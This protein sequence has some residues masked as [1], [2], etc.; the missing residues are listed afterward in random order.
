MAMQAPKELLELAIHRMSTRFSPTQRHSGEA[1]PGLYALLRG[2]FVRQ[3]SAG[4]YSLLPNGERVRA[5]IEGIIDQEMHRIG[6]LASWSGSKKLKS[7][8]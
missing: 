4:V 2:G 5:K 1:Q 6:W 8:A 3:S 7:S